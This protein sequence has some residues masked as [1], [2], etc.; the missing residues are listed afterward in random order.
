MTSVVG[1]QAASAI[2]EDAKP[3]KMVCTVQNVLAGRK[4]LRTEFLQRQDRLPQM[5]HGY[6]KYRVSSFVNAA[7]TWGTLHAA[8]NEIIAA[9]TL[10]GI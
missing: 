3:R 2:I 10:K 1:L 6:T 5:Q 7:S 4:L 8:E 9:K